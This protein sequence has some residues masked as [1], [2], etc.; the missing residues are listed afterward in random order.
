LITSSNVALVS[1]IAI[2]KPL[3]GSYVTAAMFSEGDTCQ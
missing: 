3:V 2:A 1:V